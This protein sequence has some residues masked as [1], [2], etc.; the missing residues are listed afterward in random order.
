MEHVKFVIS[1]L[2][3]LQPTCPFIVLKGIQKFTLKYFPFW[4]DENPFICLYIVLIIYIK[5]I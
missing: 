4:F 1:R 2:F 3:I 5:Y